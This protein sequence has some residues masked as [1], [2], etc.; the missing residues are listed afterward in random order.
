MSSIIRSLTRATAA[1]AAQF[2][3]SFSSSTGTL[4]RTVLYDEHVKLGGKIV[5]F[6]GYELPVQYKDGMI[7]SHT[8]CRK[9]ASVFDVSHMGQLR[10]WGAKR[11][12]FLESIVVGDLQA[13]Q[14]NQA[15]LSVMLNERGGIIDDC[16][17]TRKDDHIYMVINAGCKEKDLKHMYEQLEAYN[18]KNG[19]DVKIEIFSE[20]MELLALQGPQ[21]HV[22]LQRLVGKEVDL[23]K[24][25]FL[26]ATKANV[27]GVP[28]EISR[29]GYTGEDGFEISI[30]RE[31][32]VHVFHALLNEPEVRAAGLGVRDSLR[33]EAGL[34]LYGH[35]LNEDISPIEASLN[36][37][38]S[39]RR[40]EQG[41]FL[42]FATVDK[43]LKEGVSKK[44]VGLNVLSGAPAREDAPIVDETGKTV[45]KVTSGTHSPILKRAVAMGYVDTA[46]SKIGTKLKVVVRGKQGDAEITKMPFVATNYYKPA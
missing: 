7:D 46:H 45:G 21:A 31:K 3:R 30:P 10:I 5:P 34:C 33:L 6:A 38:I 27:A 11:L 24:I 35:D 43:H 2:A 14:T 4:H 15:R 12:E 29:C 19:S 41:G 37:L 9:N 18:K 40:R 22:V 25:P 44:R 17:I 16:M 20:K 23:A 42:G 36:W 32:T 26:F 13:L 39:K 1:S 8:H 28:C